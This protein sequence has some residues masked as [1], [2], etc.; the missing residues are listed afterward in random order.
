M[1]KVRWGIL[2]TAKIGLD[3][4]IP[5][6]QKC[7]SCEIDAIASRDL[8]KARSAAKQLG[9][10]KAYGSYEELL[11]D[12]EIDAI[13]NPLPNHLH[14]SWSIKCLEAG[15]HV[16]CEKPVGMNSLEAA[17]L[18]KEARRHPRLKIM[19][20]FMYRM[21]PQWQLARRLVSEGQ[22][23][24]LRTIQT[25][26]S[27]YNVNP[28][29]IRNIAEIGGGGLL[30][31]G[32]YCISIS[33]FIFGSEPRRVVG[34]VEYDPQLKTDRLASAMLEFAGGTATFTCST[35]L[36]AYQRANILG[37][38]GRI[39]VE[40]PVNAPPDKPCRVWHQRGTEIQ[41]HT[42]EIC[43]Q[44]SI[45]G[46]LFSQAILENKEVPTPLDDALANMRA[47]EA[48]FESAKN[49]RWVDC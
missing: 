28:E 44:Y 38:E 35:Q 22:I 37:T 47:I 19:E 31:I 5:A 7:K 16:L 45:Q 17:A 29:N 43:D 23:G 36:S 39:E 2:S 10:P 1:E 26:F 18:V 25:F 33:R 46:D 8:E 48:V 24:Q 9:I 12:E 30:D 34:V 40:I 42:L 6:M 3:K 15:K 20:A 14:V 21:H 32:C 49:G 41:Q 4:V 13:Y 27:Y 11:A